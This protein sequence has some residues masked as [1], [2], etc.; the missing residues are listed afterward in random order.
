MATTI[1]QREI[2]AALRA[3]NLSGAAI[4]VH[5]SLRS[6]GH[7]VAGAVTIREAFLDL[8]L[9]N[10]FLAMDGIMRLMLVQRRVLT[11]STPQRQMK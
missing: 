5:A 7:V 2:R 8:R 11:E 10:A 9:G 3:L 6:F 4:C 1:T